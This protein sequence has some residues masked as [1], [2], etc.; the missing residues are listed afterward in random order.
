MSREEIVQK[1]QEIFRDVFDDE[2]LIISDKTKEYVAPQTLNK[3]VAVV[4]GNIIDIKDAGEL[5]ETDFKLREPGNLF[6]T[7]QHGLPPFKVANLLRDQEILEEARQAARETL[8]QDPGLSAS[9]LRLVRQQMLKR[10]GAA[11]E[12]GDVG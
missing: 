11:L 6:G 9:D 7:Q 10:Y 8:D 5:S 4:N 12:L 1:V 3:N 2:E